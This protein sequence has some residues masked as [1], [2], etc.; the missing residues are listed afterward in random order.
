MVEI[1]VDHVAWLARLELT[2]EEK[3]VFGRQLRQILEHAAAISSLDIGDVPPTSH[4]LPLSNVMREDRVEP[5]LSR[6]EALSGAP[7]A[8]GGYFVVPRIF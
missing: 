5:S 6:E 3:E 4:P 2:E 8:E 7:R 1:D